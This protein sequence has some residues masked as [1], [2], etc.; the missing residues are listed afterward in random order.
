MT[1]QFYFDVDPLKKPLV[2]YGFRFAL[3]SVR[4]RDVELK[5]TEFGDFLAC[6]NGLF[7]RRKADV[8]C[9]FR[10]GGKVPT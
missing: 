1:E 7:C 2:A 9:P 3:C 5:V 10:A 4:K 8:A 6:V